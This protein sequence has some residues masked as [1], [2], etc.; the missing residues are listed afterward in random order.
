MASPVVDDAILAQIPAIAAPAGM[1]SNLVNPSNDLFVV[2]VATYII[3]IF[4]VVM[5]VSI[6]SFTK[7]YLMRSMQVED[8]K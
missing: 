6:R 8:C 3:C 4:L 1:Q 5:S 2:S 7:A